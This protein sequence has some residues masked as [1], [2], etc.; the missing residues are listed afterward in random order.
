MML[1]CYNS[2]TISHKNMCCWFLHKN[3]KVV[4]SSSYVPS[5]V[6]VTDQLNMLLF[7]PSLNRLYDYPVSGSAT[8]SSDDENNSVTDE[9]EARSDSA[10][11]EVVHSNTPTLVHFNTSA[12]TQNTPP[13]LVHD[14]NGTNSECSLIGNVT[15]VPYCVNSAFGRFDN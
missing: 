7:Y 10:E 3:L 1:Y 15:S 6:T 8:N 13:T 2:E 4:S 11:S 12:P 9:P 14:V 5:P